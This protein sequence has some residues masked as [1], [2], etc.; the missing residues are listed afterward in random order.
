[1]FTYSIHLVN[2]DNAPLLSIVI[3]WITTIKIILPDEMSA[4]VMSW[5]VVVISSVSSSSSTSLCLGFLLLFRSISSKTAPLS[6]WAKWS[7]NAVKYLQVKV[8]EINY[9]YNLEIFHSMTG[10]LIDV[11]FENWFN[12]YL[13]PKKY[14]CITISDEF[15]FR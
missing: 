12:I 10:L 5:V 3:V 8:K 1:M 15:L 9:L 6:C 4:R 2:T 14:F 13:E 7:W 11:T